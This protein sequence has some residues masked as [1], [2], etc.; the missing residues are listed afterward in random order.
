MKRLTKLLLIAG[1]LGLA[2]LT[3]YAYLTDL[4]P[5][6]SEVRLPVILNADN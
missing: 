1:G 4:S 6:Q 3:A 5:T 2:G